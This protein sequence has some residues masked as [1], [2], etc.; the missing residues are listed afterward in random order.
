[1]TMMIFVAMEV[2]VVVEAPSGNHLW[3]MAMR[4]LLGTSSVVMVMTISLLV[5]VVA[6]GVSITITT[7]DN[8]FC[9]YDQ[10]E[11][12]T[13]DQT[14]TRNQTSHSLLCPQNLVPVCILVGRLTME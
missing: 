4:I 6:V 1:M 13:H 10:T 9:T 12:S 14:E 7:A 8:T 5:V 2:V 11:T 3:M